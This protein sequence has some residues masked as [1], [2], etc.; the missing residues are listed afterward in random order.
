VGEVDASQDQRAIA[1][2][3]RALAAAPRGAIVVTTSD[4]DTFALWYYH[5][6]LSRRPDIVVVVE[7]LLAFDWYRDNLRAVYPTLRLPARTDTTWIEA[8][9]IANPTLG[10]ICRTDTNREDALTCAASVTGWVGTNDRLLGAPAR[11]LQERG[12][13]K[14]RPV[15]GPTSLRIGSGADTDTQLITR[16]GSAGYRR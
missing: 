15:I 3:T 10:P 6:A 1:F 2:A 14:G 7:P 9:A 12:N 4:R 5:Y 11:L 8:I 16:P 13:K